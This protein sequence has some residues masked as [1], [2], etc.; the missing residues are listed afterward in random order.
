[1]RILVINS[2]SS[3]LKFALYNYPSSSNISI[4]EL[5]E[6]DVSGL[7]EELGTPHA[8]LIMKHGSKKDSHPLPNASHK[9]A[10]ATLTQLLKQRNILT[11]PPDAIG[12][13]IVHGGEAFCAPT[14]ISNDVIDSIKQ[15]T[16]LAPLHNP[17]GI[18]GIEVARELFANTPQVAVFDTAFHQSLPPHA[19]HYAIP[20]RFYTEQGLRRYGFHGTSHAYVSQ[21]AAKLLNFNINNSRILSAHL[22]NGC[23]TAAILNGKSVDTSMGLTPLEGLVMGTRCGDIDPGLL[24]FLAQQGLQANELSTLL[25]KQSGLLGISGQAS[26]MRKLQSLAKDG[27]PHAELALSIF[28]YRASKSLAG[29]SLATQGVDTLIFTGGIGENDALMRQRILEPLAYLGLRIDQQRNLNPHQSNGVITA[30]D[31]QATAIVIC[32]N[33]EGMIAHLSA[34]TLA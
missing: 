17:S 23:S 26:D 29:M 28:A 8:T 31:S 33:E 16:H 10:L 27:D 6:A 13:R 22:G 30:A 7:A 19:Y 3:S 25:N 34:Q 11:S 32:T 24:I 4:D 5:P 2:G 9:E 12:H 14:R 21:K 20:Q 18:L 1:M 15:C